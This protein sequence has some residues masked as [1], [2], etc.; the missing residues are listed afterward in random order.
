V[1]TF[2]WEFFLFIFGFTALVLLVMGPGNWSST[3]SFPLATLGR[4][5]VKKL[6]RRS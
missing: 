3:T 6:R 1:E 2:G 5:I 4:W